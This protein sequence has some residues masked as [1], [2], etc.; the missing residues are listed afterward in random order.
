MMDSRWSQIPLT[1]GSL[2]LKQAQHWTLSFQLFQKKPVLLPEK[3]HTQPSLR[4]RVREEVSQCGQCGLIAEESE[5]CFSCIRWK[6]GL[7]WEEDTL[8]GE[9]FLETEEN[10]EAPGRA[11][12][13]LW[14]F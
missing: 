11:H 2:D 3:A 12:C 9:D 4:S 8:N 1:G 7:L 14:L 6:E 10:Q 13:S 5:P